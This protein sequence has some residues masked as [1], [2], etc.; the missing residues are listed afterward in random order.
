M[1]H[2]LCNDGRPSSDGSGG[3]RT[4]PR[5][6]SR[7]RRTTRSWPTRMTQRPGVRAGGGRPHHGGEQPRAGQG[8]QRP[9]RG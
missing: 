8:R 2:G 1:S 3:P 4:R 5:P 7:R 9:G 6:S